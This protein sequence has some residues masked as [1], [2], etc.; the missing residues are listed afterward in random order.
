VIAVAI[1]FLNALEEGSQ[2]LGGLCLDV[3]AFLNCDRDIGKLRDFWGRRQKEHIEAAHLLL[4]DINCAAVERVN[5][6]VR[7]N[8][9]LHDDAP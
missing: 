7:E 4:M 2:Q 1:S 3:L 5:I 8:E 9:F 6:F